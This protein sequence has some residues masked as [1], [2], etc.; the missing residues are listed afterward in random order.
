MSTPIAAFVAE[1]EDLIV[2]L[3]HLVQRRNA[4]PAYPTERQSYEEYSLSQGERESAQAVVDACERIF[5]HRLDKV[6]PARD[7]K[8]YGN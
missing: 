3:F 6:A 2:A 7:G 4:R 8:S 1:N 5:L